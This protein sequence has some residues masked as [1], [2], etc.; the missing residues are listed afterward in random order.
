VGGME[1]TQQEDSSLAGS[2]VQEQYVAGSGVAHGLASPDPFERDVEG[3]SSRRRSGSAGSGETASASGSGAMPS[4]MSTHM[5]EFS[6]SADGTRPPIHR[7][8]RAVGAEQ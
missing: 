7:I 8:H 1:V 5:S 4:S 2:S 6:R 3:T